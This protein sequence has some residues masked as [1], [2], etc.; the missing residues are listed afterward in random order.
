MANH[1]IF[2]YTK[3]LRESSSDGDIINFDFLLSLKDI[4]K[5]KNRMSKIYNIVKCIDIELYRN[6]NDSKSILQ[7]EIYM[8][9]E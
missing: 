8:N 6:F 3:I 9:I 1:A 4:E 2:N 5:F 7:I